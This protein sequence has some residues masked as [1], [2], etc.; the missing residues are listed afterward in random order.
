[1]RRDSSGG[2]SLGLDEFER[3]ALAET[4]PAENTN[5]PTPISIKDVPQ[6]SALA[7]RRGKIRKSTAK[8]ARHVTIIIEARY[9]VRNGLDGSE[10]FPD[11]DVP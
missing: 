7:N 9:V 2:C 8:I 5:E 10:G 11:E 6:F 4:T 3:M 1:M